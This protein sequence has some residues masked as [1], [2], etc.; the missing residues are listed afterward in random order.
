MYFKTC[1]ISGL[2][3]SNSIVLDTLEYTTYVME[4]SRFSI[5]DAY[6]YYVLVHTYL[7]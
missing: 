1:P 5:F 2:E 7:P 4:K 6:F 3:N